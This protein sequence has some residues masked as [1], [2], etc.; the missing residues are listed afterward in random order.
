[1]KSAVTAIGKPSSK[2]Q[3]IA[4]IVQPKNQL[5]SLVSLVE[6]MAFLGVQMH[7]RDDTDSQPFLG[8][9]ATVSA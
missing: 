8:I 2:Q 4:A 5:I 1:M 9:Q 7:E 3:N 6:V